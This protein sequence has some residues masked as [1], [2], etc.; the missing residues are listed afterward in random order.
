MH[1]N[2][3]I[4]AQS[5]QN[6]SDSILHIIE[7]VAA[8][9]IDAPVNFSGD[10]F[11]FAVAKTDAETDLYTNVM[12][13]SADESDR[14]EIQFSTKPRED[15][16]CSRMPA[17]LFIPKTVFKEAQIRSPAV[18][19]YAFKKDSLFYSNQQ[20]DEESTVAVG[21]VVSYILSTSI[22]NATVSNLK[23]PIEL[24]FAIPNTTDPLKTTCS[25]WETENR[26]KT[27]IAS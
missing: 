16:S 18:Y 15:T 10:N 21:N 11:G 1:V 22:H 7:K 14:L 17:G 23:K 13:P 27:L 4:I 3:T 20:E 26:G 8:N 19:A 24:S 5:K 2:K 25:F 6:T 9:S 12:I